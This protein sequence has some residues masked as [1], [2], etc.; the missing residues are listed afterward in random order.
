MR[1]NKVD[2]AGEKNGD[3]LLEAAEDIPR[4]E[5]NSL[6]WFSDPDVWYCDCNPLIFD[7]DSWPLIPQTSFLKLCVG[8][9]RGF[10]PG[11]L[12]ISP[13]PDLESWTFCPIVDPDFL[14]RS[15]TPWSR[16]KENILGFSRSKLLMVLVILSSLEMLLGLLVLVLN[17]IFIFFGQNTGWYYFVDSLGT[18]LKVVSSQMDIYR[19]MDDTWMK[20]E[21]WIMSE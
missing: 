5:K 9:I 18:E 4:C 12:I 2:T 6:S 10:N 13:D 3:L 11:P 15:L 1:W 17:V 20:P 8:G 19:W 21:Y 14:Y 7:P 16:C